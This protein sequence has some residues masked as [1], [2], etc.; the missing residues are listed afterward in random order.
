MERT[1]FDE[2]VL[3]ERDRDVAECG[4]LH[5]VSGAVFDQGVLDESSS[6]PREVKSAGS[7]GELMKVERDRSSTR[8]GLI[9]V[10]WGVTEGVLLL[11]LR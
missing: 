3:N 9:R 11:G 4:R 6:G 7:T 5:L 2:D 8:C 10:A 1:E